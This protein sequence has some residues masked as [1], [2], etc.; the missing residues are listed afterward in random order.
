MNKELIGTFFHRGN[1]Q[2]PGL[3]AYGPVRPF[4]P[5][6]RRCPVS[7]P[8]R[9]AGA[10][11]KAIIRSHFLGETLSSWTILVIARPNTAFSRSIR[12][13]VSVPP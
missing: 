4:N 12:V 1:H 11:R 2:A 8:F 10:M 5:G 3:S 13:G 9:L 6:A 7:T